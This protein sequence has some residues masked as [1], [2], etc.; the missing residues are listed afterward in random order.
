MYTVCLTACLFV[1]GSA[2]QLQQPWHDPSMQWTWPEVHA[3][4]APGI[5]SHSMCE[6]GKTTAQCTQRG[7]KRIN[8]W[9]ESQWALEKML[10]ATK[11]T[12][13]LAYHGYIADLREK[14]PF[15]WNQT[16]APTTCLPQLMAH[17]T[18]DVDP[19]T[20]YCDGGAQGAVDMCTGGAATADPTGVRKTLSWVSA[21]LKGI[22]DLIVDSKTAECG[23]TQDDPGLGYFG[24]ALAKIKKD[25]MWNQG[26]GRCC[27]ADEIKRGCKAA[28]GFNDTTYDYGKDGKGE[29]N[30]ARFGMDSYESSPK[31]HLEFGATC[32][33]TESFWVCPV[34]N[35][36]KNFPHGLGFNIRNNSNHITN[37][38]EKMRQF[39]M[40]FLG[41]ASG[42][43][44]DRILSAVAVAYEIRGSHNWDM[45]L[46]GI[47]IL[48]VIAL[49]GGGHHSLGELL[50]GAHAAYLVLQKC[51]N[52]DKDF[53]VSSKAPLSDAHFDWCILKKYSKSL[54]DAGFA[55]ES[56]KTV[57]TTMMN[58]QSFTIPLT[59]ALMYNKAI[60]EFIKKTAPSGRADTVCGQY[61]TY[62]SGQSTTG[63][64]FSTCG[65][66]YFK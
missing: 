12:N 57:Y 24:Q 52:K 41:G 50:F 43:V 58:I 38:A 60:C 10:G 46:G 15:L 39:D 1:C 9:I 66:D 47:A 54:A 14:I 30:G 64:N 63:G 32:K 19:L 17:M 62:L 20:T 22:N 51:E 28:M 34:W 4:W 8:M 59:Q 49:V 5:Q 11:C 3:K 7:N 53:F 37:P 42:S 36:N 13:F 16:G 65:N 35:A 56:L 40:P 21:E 45:N 6:L 25:G 48:E 27:C 31:F 44:L 29:E 61:L 26:K 55:G 18:G 23:L 2:L 33:S